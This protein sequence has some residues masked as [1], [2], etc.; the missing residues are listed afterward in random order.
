MDAHDATTLNG[1]TVLIT[2]AAQR[3]GAEIARA[4]HRQGANIALHF[5]SSRE[6]ARR[7][8]SE[9]EDQRSE[10]I[11]L[12]Q[13]DLLKTG[14]ASNVIAKAQQRW[15]RLDAL[16]NNASA[17]YPTPI[18]KIDEKSW[19]E[20]M[21]SNL[22][23]PLLLSQAAAPHLKES[24][25]SIINLVDIHG[26]RPLAGH[27]VYCAAKAGLVMLTQSLALELAPE[28]RV[29][30]IAPGAILPPPDKE[31]IPQ[32][33]VD[34]VPLQRAGEPSDIA[35]TIAFLVQPGAYITGQVIAVDGGKSL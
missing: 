17:F 26:Q 7:L 6:Q 11:E 20:L 9:L 22:K 2:G 15:R 27:V 28:V 5:R 24:R 8:A 25:G 33:M 21:G 16:I 1:K 34:Q 4:L 14:E 19:D 31:A 30:A 29:N 32:S 3:I 18:G 12:I 23:A 10:S 35:Q 13:A